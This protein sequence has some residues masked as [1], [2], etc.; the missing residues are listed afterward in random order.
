MP[1]GCSRHH[2][3]QPGSGNRPADARW[4]AR[5]RSPLTVIG[6]ALVTEELDPLNSRVAL[7]SPSRIRLLYVTI[8]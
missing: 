2:I 4:T 7:L 8:K 3:R 1:A 6:M 5:F